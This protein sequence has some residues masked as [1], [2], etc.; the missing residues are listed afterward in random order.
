MKKL[1]PLILLFI[2]CHSV[3]A[4]RWTGNTDTNW[5]TAT[6]WI[7]N[8]VP[9]GAG[10]VVI[11]SGLMNYPALQTDVSMNSIDM[12]NGS[13][14]NV[15]GYVLTV[16]GNAAASNF[17]GAT[18]NNSNAATD[19]VINL[20]TGAG[21]SSSYFNSNTVNDNLVLNI[22]GSKDFYEGAQEPGNHYNGDVLF[23]INGPLT[24]YITGA[25]TSAFGG[26]LSINRTVA[27]HTN[28]FQGIAIINGNFS[29]TNPASGNTLLGG[30]NTTNIGGILNITC[31]PVTPGLFDMRKLV[32]NTNG[33]NISLQNTTGFNLQNNSLK[34]ATL[35]INGYKIGQFGYLDNNT[36]TGDV[37]I[38]DDAGY[39]DGYNTSVMNNTI[40]GNTAF[41]ING[42]NDFF[43]APNLNTTNK[44][45]GNVSFTASGNSS[46]YI[47]HLDSLYCTGNVSITRTA[48]G[49]TESF[50]RGATIHGNFSYN[51]TGG[52]AYLGGAVLTGIDGTI[53][54]TADCNNAGTFQLTNFTNHTSGGNITIQNSQG[55]NLQNDTLQLSSLNITGY[56]NGQNGVLNSSVLS[57]DINISD[58]AGFGGGYQTYISGNTITGNSAFTINGNGTFYDKG[59]GFISNRYNGSV[60]FTRNAGTMQIGNLGFAEITKDLTLNGDAGMIIGDIKF[61]G[62]ANSIWKQLGTQPVELTTLAMEKTGGS[63]TLNTP[64]RITNRGELNGGVIYTTAVNTITFTA[65][66]S[67][68]GGSN[69]SYID[70]PATKNGNTSFIFP[71]GKSGR[72]AR[73]SIGGGGD[74]ADAFTAEYFMHSASDSGYPVS[75][76]D[77]ALHHVSSREFWQLRRTTGNTA[78][79]VTLS[80]DTARSGGINNI[81]D[82][83]VASWS[84]NLWKNEGQGFISGNNG[85]G[86]I[87]SSGPVNDFIAFTLASAASSNPL[88]VTL[89]SF[90]AAR[91]NDQVRLQW[92]TENEMNIA[93]Y[94]V[95]RSADGLHY[96]T[97]MNQLPQG[98]A[99]QNIYR[100]NDRYPLAG[101]NYYRLK[102]TDIGGRFTYSIIATVNIGRKNSISIWPNPAKDFFTITNA[103]DYKQV[104]ITDITGKLVRQVNR[105]AD[106]RYPLN[107]LAKGLYIVR[108]TGTS[109]TVH[110]KLIVE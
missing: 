60:S 76:K 54:I 85:S 44:Y 58:D 1:Y 79:V 106:H 3:S 88:P 11:P 29:Y 83:R 33:G 57:A 7:G 80:W 21:V 62:T 9:A 65:G 94:W 2:C 5:N 96:S 56:K 68:T 95:E 91:N 26:N 25:S 74:I 64:I 27:G 81:S 28:A 84:G 69:T 63:L 102:I 12:Q 39:S 40:T 42:S 19:I 49:L 51:S 104:L 78:T 8:M 92:I 48:T 18:L 55:F 20:N 22:S 53:N 23:N 17:T 35:N 103:G 13:S 59:T 30:A 14:L 82:L 100:V 107:G 109:E 36:I 108:L 98:N 66:S 52:A 86:I 101:T 110:A 10:H 89:I 67:C 50:Y 71:A 34:I 61:K 4:Q 73:I 70:G 37:T 15:N 41:I 24:C 75:Q 87:S 6:N 45:F 47:A 46:L 38:A 93:A 31:H 105:S 16:T 77:P 97:L 72:I 43:E 90:N 32:N 99:A